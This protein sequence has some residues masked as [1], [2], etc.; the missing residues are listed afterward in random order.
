MSNQ[1]LITGKNSKVGLYLQWHGGMDSVAPFLEYASFHS[2]Q[3]LGEE[4]SDNGLATLVT[5]INNSMEFDSVYVVP[6]DPE[7]LQEEDYLSGN[8]NGVYVVDGDWNIIQRIDAP[9][10]EQNCHDYATMLLTID[11]TQPESMQLGE[12]FLNAKVIPTSEV[13]VGMTVFKKGI[14]KKG[15]LRWEK[16]KVQHIGNPTGDPVP[17]MFPENSPYTGEYPESNPNGYVLTETVRAIVD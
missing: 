16:H 14:L 4:V 17:Q 12:E 6:V 15:I 13:E 1:A 5:I 2:S 9:E 8:E 3:G 11:Q 10:V 7:E